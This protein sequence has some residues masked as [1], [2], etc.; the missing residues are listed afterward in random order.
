[1]AI[2][3]T[4]PL[5]PGDPPARAAALIYAE[6]GLHPVPVCRPE[7]ESPV[8]CNCSWHRGLRD[9]PGKGVGKTPLLRAARLDGEAGPGLLQQAET[10]GVTAA[11]VRSMPWGGSNVGLCLQPSGLAVLDLDGTEAAA[12]AVGLGL[13]Y[14]A[15][16]RRGDH[17]HCYYRLPEAVP[18]LRAIRQG[19]CGKIDVLDTGYVLA[20]PSLHGSGDRYRLASQR[21][22]AALP[23]WAGRL[24]REAARRRA[25]EVRP[26]PGETLDPPAVLDLLSFKH[27]PHWVIARIRDGDRSGDRSRTDWSVTRVLVEHGVPDAAI[28]SIYRNPAWRIGAKYRERRDPDRYL[29][30]MLTRHHAAVAELRAGTMQR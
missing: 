6:A 9:H 13:P 23:A 27:V 5:I 2:P 24:L 8:G 1:M 29:A 7:P 22:F 20:P 14:T 15:T 18:A 16:V 4:M 11:E 19:K 28:A 3:E 17:A 30:V 25:L 12:E 21:P 26:L 10:E